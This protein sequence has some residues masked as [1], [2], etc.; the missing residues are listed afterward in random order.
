MSLGRQVLREILDDIETEFFR[1]LQDAKT[2][3][4]LNPTI[5]DLL[6]FEYQRAVTT[7]IAKY[8]DKVYLG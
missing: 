1:R 3:E 7:A 5:V 8:L 2:K 4:F 6:E